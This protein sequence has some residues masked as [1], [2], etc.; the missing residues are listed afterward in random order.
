MS[1]WKQLF[2]PSVVL[3]EQEK[4]DKEEQEWYEDYMN[5]C[6]YQQDY[7]QCTSSKVV[8]SEETVIGK[9]FNMFNEFLAINKNAVIKYKRPTSWLYPNKNADEI[10]CIREDVVKNFITKIVKD[11]WNTYVSLNDKYNKHRFVNESNIYYIPLDVF[12]YGFS[13]YNDL[14][15]IVSFDEQPIPDM[16]ILSKKEPPMNISVQTRKVPNVNNSI[17]SNNNSNVFLPEMKT[18]EHY[19]QKTPQKKSEFLIK[20]SKKVK[21]Y[22]KSLKK[23]KNKE[24]VSQITSNSQ[25]NINSQNINQP[26]KST[27]TEKQE[28]DDENIKINENYVR[29]KFDINTSMYRKDFAGI[30]KD[31]GKTKKTSKK[32]TNK[33]K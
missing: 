31:G 2:S 5:W 3:I 16:P 29:R 32:K 23:N 28:V 20:V 19:L 26:E 7:N 22:L 10:Y 27:N 8:I 17:S 6:D 15:K 33:K 1:Y 14:M 4:A 25:Q 18:F 11:E 24:Q 12:A 30:I 13:R 21:N 9:L